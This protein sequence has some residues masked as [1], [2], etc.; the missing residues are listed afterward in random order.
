MKS[1]RIVLSGETFTIV[2]Y[3]RGNVETKRK[4]KELFCMV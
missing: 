3:Q 1:I 4:K 2:T